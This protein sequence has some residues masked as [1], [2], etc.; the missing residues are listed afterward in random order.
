MWNL[1]ETIKYI[2]FIKQAALKFAD[3][4]TRRQERV[5]SLMAQEMRS[6]NAVQCRSHHQK[7]V[8]AYGTLENIISHYEANVIP[9]YEARAKKNHIKSDSSEP[10]DSVESWCSVEVRKSAFCIEINLDAMGSF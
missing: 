10:S 4:Q 3:E 9:Y 7:M 5:F 6:R 1:P 2:G 8:Q